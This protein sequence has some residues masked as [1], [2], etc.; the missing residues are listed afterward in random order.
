MSLKKYSQSHDEHNKQ[1]LDMT[2]ANLNLNDV[3]RNI[4]EE[5]QHFLL[6]LYQ[7]KKGDFVIKSMKKRM[8]TLL[9]TSIRT[10]IAF[11][12]SKLSACFQVKNKTKFGHNHDIVYHGT[13][14]KTDCPENYIGET[15]RRISE[16]AKD[17]TGRYVR[18]HLFKH[19]VESGHEVL[20]VTYYSIIGKGYRNNNRKRK[21][22]E[23]L[24]IKEIKP[25]PNRK[26]QSIA[27][28]I[29]S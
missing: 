2:Y 19:A 18:S 16:R 12:G 15:A 20:D 13:C 25:T 14:Y 21:I 7:G 6:V 29:F 26:D 22:A 9:P 5:E 11:T 23:A 3:E 27:L 4:N 8:K 17:H 1:E 28:K 24:L 10:K